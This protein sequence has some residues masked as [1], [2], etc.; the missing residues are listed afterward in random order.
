M[1]E[2]VTLIAWNVVVFIVSGRRSTERIVNSVFHQIKALVPSIRINTDISMLA[3]ADDN[4][5]SMFKKGAKADIIICVIDEQMTAAADKIDAA[6][7]FFMDHVDRVFKLLNLEP[8]TPKAVFVRYR[9]ETTNKTL[10]ARVDEMLASYEG[11]HRLVGSNK[12]FEYSLCEL[13]SIYVLPLEAMPK[14][15]LPLQEPGPHFGLGA[16]GQIASMPIARLDQQGNDLRRINQL[17]P[18]IRE[19]AEDFG[20]NSGSLGNQHPSIV[21][22]VSRYLQA[23]STETAEIDW[24]MVWGLGVR[25][26]AATAA[27]ERRMGERLAPELEDEPLTALQSLRNLHAP[28]ILA[29]IEGREL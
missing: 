10:R 15:E 13:L 16:S 6:P 19:C 5:G 23:I 4:F 22:D 17:L 27:A 2:T 25:L 9:P 14:L 11:S 28:L 7:D 21:R 18:L 29:T 1:P 26:E 24:G 8:N 3:S 12:E 20:N